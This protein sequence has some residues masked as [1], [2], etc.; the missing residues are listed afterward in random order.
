MVERMHSLFLKRIPICFFIGLAVLGLSACSGDPG[1]SDAKKILETKIAEQSEGMV[2]LVDFEKTNG[3]KQS[4]G[5]MELYTL[6]YSA[7]FEF[8]Q[9]SWK[10]CDPFEGCFSN[11]YF[12]KEAPRGM[13]AAVLSFKHFGKGSKVK[14]SGK[15][16]F[17]KTEKGWRAGQ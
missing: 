7:T 14:T 12:I 2:K 5:G 9:E 3:I 16:N 15:M 1:V 6:E 4:I 11:F 8:Q 10:E 17:Q 13:E